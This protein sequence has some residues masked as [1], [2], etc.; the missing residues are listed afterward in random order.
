MNRLFAACAWN[1]SPVDGT[2]IV[3]SFA[4]KARTFHFP[5][6]LQTDN[7]IARI[8]QQGEATMQHV[9][10]M[11]LMWFRQKEL[12]KVLIDERRTKHGEMANQN[13]TKRTFETGDIVLVR[14]QVTSSAKE[15]KPAKLTLK[16]RGV[17]RVLEEAGEN[18]CHIQKLPAVQSLTKRPGKR[19]KE[20]A[21]H[22][23]DRN[24]GFYDFGRCT[25]APG[26]A[27][28]AF[29]KT[30]D[31]WNEELSESDEKS[32]DD[33]SESDD[34]TAQETK[35]TTV[36]GLRDLLNKSLSARRTYRRGNKERLFHRNV[37]D[38]GNKASAFYV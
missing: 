14:K 25:T 23:L 35:T 2:A 4:A 9:E 8:P 16:A 18:A 24:L 17:Y 38:T 33:S 29:E 34:N 7:E 37:S 30:H 31:L 36:L 1:G 5:L 13:K 22:P 27:N 3:R 12:L 28:Y 26:D 11:F 21:T 19:M 32:D 10:T 20:L 6:D 15:G